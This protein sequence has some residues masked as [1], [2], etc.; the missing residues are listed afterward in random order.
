[1]EL[2]RMQNPIAELDGDEMTRIVWKQIKEELLLPFL[3]LK[4]EYYDLGL[5]NREK[6]GDQVTIEASEAIKRL[7]VGVK[8]ATITP[9]A[10]RMKEYGLTRM[11]KSPNGTIRFIL[12]G[13]VFRK[14]ILVPGIAP[15]VSN[16]KKPI[17]IARHAFGDIYRSAEYMADRPG[18]AELSYNDQNGETVFTA[19]IAEL[20]EG[21]VIM[22]QFNTERSIRSFAESCFRYAVNEREDLWFSAKDTIS[23]IYDQR[24][25]DIFEELYETGYRKEFERLGIKYR[26]MLI[27]SAAAGIMR[28]E[29]GM[30]WAC[31]NYDGDV[32]SDLISAAFGSIAMMS[33]V[34][35]SPD[36]KYEYEAAHGT[37]TDLYYR[38]KNGEKVSVNPTAMIFAWTGALA[39]RG[40][41]DGS[42]ELSGFAERLESACID[43]IASG[44]VTGDLAPL[45]GRKP[46][47][48]MTFLSA[49][50]KRME[51]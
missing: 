13:T 22:G 42:R 7:G 27:D 49:V 11:W 25:R 6:T 30:I 50:R 37:V 33:S 9:N 18:H 10:Q 26:Y 31:K 20:S 32:M 3:E 4:T 2:I 35:V 39:K 46:V 28:S 44:I 1:M 24:F 21:D 38:Y 48:T 29:G 15:L 45:C 36:G 47:D 41:L 43:T 40:E 5:E 14:P 19:N 8:C 17:T 16:W 51:G 12:D 23:K 34:L